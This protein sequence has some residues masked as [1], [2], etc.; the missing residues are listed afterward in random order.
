[1][2][3]SGLRVQGI[4]LIITIGG[5]TSGWGSHI[6]HPSG[7]E[8]PADVCAEGVRCKNG[9]TGCS[10]M[11]SEPTDAKLQ[12]RINKGSK[13][14]HDRKLAPC[15]RFEVPSKPHAN[16]PK[17][18]IVSMKAPSKKAFPTPLPETLNPLKPDTPN[19]KT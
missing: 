14:H 6:S 9:S 8:L 4:I 16:V 19:A 15:E 5:N 10:I 2:A 7:Y 18:V 3:G 17:P 11:R 13:P 1:M 12:T